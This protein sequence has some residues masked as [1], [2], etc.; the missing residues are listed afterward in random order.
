MFVVDSLTYTL[1]VPVDQ[2]RTRQGRLCCIAL[3]G[4]FEQGVPFVDRLV[5]VLV[6]MA[7]RVGQQTV[8]LPLRNQCVASLA[9]S[10]LESPV[11]V[12]WT[13]QAWACTSLASARTHRV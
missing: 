7:A 11:R 12:R 10:A 8:I 2:L 4:S 5:G 6:G 1:L 9:V 3:G 13:S